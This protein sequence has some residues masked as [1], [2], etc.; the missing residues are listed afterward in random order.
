MRGEITLEFTGREV[1]ELWKLLD[2]IE[3]F[4]SDGPEADTC[5]LVTVVKQV[6]EDE[7]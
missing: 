6:D 3:E 1:G 2:A 7:D 4:A 5:T